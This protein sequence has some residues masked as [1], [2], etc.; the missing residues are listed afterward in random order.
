MGVGVWDENDEKKFLKQDKFCLG[1]SR[2]GRRVQPHLGSLSP[3][4]R[5]QQSPGPS[6]TMWLLL[7]FSFLLT[8]AGEVDPGGSGLCPRPP[9]PTSISRPCN[10][11]APPYPE[12]V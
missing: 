9:I 3:L 6:S 8:S 2:G 4:P 7:I 10:L 1:D 5:L 11:P 12:T